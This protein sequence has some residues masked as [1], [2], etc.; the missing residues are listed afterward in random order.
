M[1]A[2]T[3]SCVVAT[4]GPW[5]IPEKCKPLVDTYYYSSKEC[6]AG[7]IELQRDKSNRVICFGPGESFPKKPIGEVQK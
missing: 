5:E 2:Y 6:H 1:L 7:S 4:S 3:V